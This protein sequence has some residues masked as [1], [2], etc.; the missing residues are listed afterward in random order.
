MNHKIKSCPNCQNILVLAT[1][2]RN[3]EDEYY[4]CPDCD[5]LYQKRTKGGYKKVYVD[6]W[7]MEIMAWTENYKIFMLSNNVEDLVYRF[8]TNYS[9][10]ERQMKKTP[11]FKPHQI[12]DQLQRNYS[13]LGL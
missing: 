10:L 7:P 9:N 1:A 6:E 12:I 11:F 13:L 2:E 4:Y 3:K 5:I 8:Q